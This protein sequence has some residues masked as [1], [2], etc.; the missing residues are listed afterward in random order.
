MPFQIYL[1]EFLFQILNDASILLTSKDLNKKNKT[2]DPFIL[3]EYIEWIVSY[4]THGYYILI[5][6]E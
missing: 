4:K 2:L 1:D 5:R 3:Y 6:K